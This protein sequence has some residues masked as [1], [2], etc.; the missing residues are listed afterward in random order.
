M[1]IEFKD[2]SPQIGL[3]IIGLDISKPLNVEILDKLR[4]AYFDKHLLVIKFQKIKENDLVA[5]SKHFAE[6]VPSLNKRFKLASHPVITRYSNIRD[7]DDEPTGAAAPEFVWHSDSYFTDNPNKATIFYSKISPKVG[8]ETHF[9]NMCTA[10]ELLS[11]EMKQKIEG[12]KVFYK[13]AFI[14]RP[15]VAHPLVRINPITHKKSLF[16]NIHRALGIDGLSI[17]E[18]MNILNELYNQS[19]QPHL[20]YCHKWCDGDLLIWDNPSTMHTATP[21]PCDQQRLLY[22]ILTKGDLPVQ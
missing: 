7:D 12:K 14:H 8:G 1:K 5:F 4:D 22:R 18:S 15:P 6:P 10:Y 2:L 16:V 3:E 17:E 9:V 13:N 20:I 11:D 19:I 21:I